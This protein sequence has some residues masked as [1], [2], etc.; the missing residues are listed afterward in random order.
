MGTGRHEANHRCKQKN[1]IH[2][3][4]LLTRSHRSVARDVFVH[5]L[6]AGLDPGVALDRLGQTE[7]IDVLVVEPVLAHAPVAEESLKPFRV[8]LVVL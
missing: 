7:G 3:F 4:C 8:P 2:L 6:G 5:V 1:A